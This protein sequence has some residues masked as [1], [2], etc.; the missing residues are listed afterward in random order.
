MESNRSLTPDDAIAQ[1][2]CMVL[3]AVI[4]T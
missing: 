4:G 1:A 2:E 3:Q